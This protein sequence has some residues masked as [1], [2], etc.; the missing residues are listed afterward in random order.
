MQEPLTSKQV[1]R[2]LQVSES[3]IKRWCDN[4]VLPVTY[5]PG[6]HRRIPLGGLIGFIRSSNHELARPEVLGLPATTGKTV[7]ILARAA[8]QMSEA[9]LRGDEEGC[10][11]I[12]LDLYLAEHPISAICDEVFSKAFDEIGQRWECGEAEVYQERRGCTI[13]VRVLSELRTLLPSTT[14]NSPIAIGSSPE[15][16]PYNLATTMAELVL[17]E[18][19]WNA[20]SLGNDLPFAT[21]AAAINQHQPRL[22]WLSVSH[23]DNTEKFLDGY[24]TFYDTFS[25]D[26]AFV[27]GG[28][29][30]VAEMRQ[31]MRYAA[32]CDNLQHLEAFARTLHLPSEVSKT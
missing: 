7:R 19:G 31:K 1:A 17:R 8:S 20:M 2:A 25:A 4:G 13:V 3:S 12:A 9:L 32:Y 14:A 15:S 23:I 21:L 30:L 29:A 28:R 18:S 16:D 22:F 5:T 11:Q 6:G 24:Q 10:R 26:V 27:V